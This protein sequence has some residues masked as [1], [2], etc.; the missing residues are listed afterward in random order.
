MVG[1]LNRQW[2]LPRE[3]NEP[4]S[5]S[6][7]SQIERF[8]L[9]LQQVDK[10]KTVSPNI[11]FIGDLNID[12]SKGR[13]HLDREELKHLIPLYE[14]YLN[15][16]NFSIINKENTRF[17]VNCQ[18]SFLDHIVTNLPNH[19]DQIGTRPSIISD[20]MR[21]SCLFHVEELQDPTRFI[22]KTEW[23]RI[24]LNNLTEHILNN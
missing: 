21:I 7:K 9:F 19:V 15:S 4:S 6:T 1:G 20:H 5:G 14:D 24:N 10:A 22:F 3:C 23:W 8:K 18:P 16:N 12:I 11:L 13:D 2:R 17:Q